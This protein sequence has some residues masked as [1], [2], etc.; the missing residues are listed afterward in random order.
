M[1]DGGAEGVIIA[2]G[3]AFGGWSLY[4]KGGK[5]KYCYNFF[6]LQLFTVEGDSEIPA[7][8]H[9]VRMEFAYDGGG[10]AKGGTVTLYIDGKQVGEGRVEATVPMVFSGRRDLRRRLGHRLA[11]DARLHPRDQPLHRRRS[12]G[13]RSTS[14]RPP[15]TST[16]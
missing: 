11:G 9:Q 1:P 3:G 10:L 14:T 7:G 12:S 5:P 4:V 6:G 13:C 15:R 2:Q 16:T 8:E